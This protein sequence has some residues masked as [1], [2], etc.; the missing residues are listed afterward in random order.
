[1][2]DKV[3]EIPVIRGVT[4]LPTGRNHKPNR[5]RWEPTIRKMEETGG[6]AFVS[7]QAVT[8]ISTAAKRLGYKVST[9]EIDPYHCWAKLEKAS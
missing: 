3:K 4:L 5:R 7:K 9:Q 1:M 6:K 2:S 8:S